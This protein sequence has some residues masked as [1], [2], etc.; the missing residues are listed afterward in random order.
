MDGPRSHPQ[1]LQLHSV[2]WGCGGTPARSPPLPLPEQLGRNR[3]P[4]S[5]C[6]RV[7]A[8]QGR[9][10]ELGQQRAAPAE[11]PQGNAV[12]FPT[13]ARG[14]STRNSGRC[15]CLPPCIARELLPTLPRTC[16][17]TE[18]PP[19][20]I[21]RHCH[22]PPREPAALQPPG[23]PGEGPIPPQSALP[24]CP[25][26]ALWALSRLRILSS[27]GSQKSPLPA[28]LPRLPGRGAATAHAQPC[29]LGQTSGSCHRTNNS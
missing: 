12:T 25:A 5:P 15:R 3:S 8:H 7:C 29:R 18:P 17:G 26:P 22:S 28:A 24:H 2:P 9:G 6:S 16:G 21:Y 4:G 10:P 27:Q 20:P 1:Q 19:C 11:Q 14:T 23:Q 13:S